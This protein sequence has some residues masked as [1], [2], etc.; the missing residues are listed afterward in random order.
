MD[1]KENIQIVEVEFYEASYGCLWY[2]IKIDNQIFKDSFS[3]VFD[4]VMDFKAWL[5]AI[6]IK[7]RQTSFFF[8][9]EGEDIKF[10]FQRIRD[11]ECKLLITENGYESNVYI[12]GSNIDRKQL[13]KAFYLGLMNFAKSDKYDSKEWEDQSMKE[14]LCEKFNLNEKKLLKKLERSSKEELKK[15]FLEEDPYRDFY[16]YDFEQKEKRTIIDDYLKISVSPWNGVKL[17]EFQ[18]DIIENFIK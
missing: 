13:V 10:D 16:D 7:V 12:Q 2:K 18:S 3:E 11:N 5:E 8:D 14:R 4:P 9:N 6:A 17:S 15:L 1:K